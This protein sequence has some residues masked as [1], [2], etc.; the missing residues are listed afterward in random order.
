MAVLDGDRVVRLV[1]KPSEFVSDLALVGV[2]LFDDSI[3][4]ARRHPGALVARRVRDHRGDPVADRPRA[5]GPCRD[6][7]GWWKDTGKPDDLLE[8]N[9]IMLSVRRPAIDGDVDE[10]TSVEGSVVVAAGAKV[11]RSAL[12]GPV[13]IGPGSVVDESTSVPTSRSSAAAGSY[14][15]T[16]ADSIVMEG[17]TIADVRGIAGSILGRGVEVRH[18]GT[19]GMHR[20]IVGDQSRVEVD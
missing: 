6:G 5:H 10:A 9:R 11:T 7:E 4:E 15:A 2:Y 8:A 16:I 12:R 17:C 1:E 20:L 13:V 18:S 14:A 19:E 3:L